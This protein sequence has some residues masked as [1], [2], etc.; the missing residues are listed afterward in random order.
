MIQPQSQVRQAPF[1]EIPGFRV[2]IVTFLSGV[3]QT[4]ITSAA[5]HCDMRYVLSE[6]TDWRKAFEQ[7]PAPGGGMVISAPPEGYRVRGYAL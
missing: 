1:C 5:S 2:K 4:E 3:S 7:N 6:Q